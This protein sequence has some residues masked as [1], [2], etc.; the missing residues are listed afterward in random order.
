MLL[1]FSGLDGSGKSTLIELLI[2]HKKARKYSI[3][4]LTMYDHIG[5]FALFRGLRNGIFKFFG[6]PIK[7]KTKLKFGNS[8]DEIIN[9]E[10]RGWFMQIIL[11]FLRQIWIKKA[12]LLL[13]IFIMHGYR[14]YFERI[15][16]NVLILD[17]YFYDSLVD[18][19][20]KKPN[21]NF[22]NM[23]LRYIPQPTISIFI[24]VP[25]K[26]SF[27]RKGEFSIEYLENRYKFYCSIFSKKPEIVVLSNLDQVTAKEEL[28]EKV[29]NQIFLK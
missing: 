2:N 18:I 8:P 4:V 3:K 21:D 24:D 14:L 1:T 17:R 9:A 19:L 5:L 6:S 25:P 27:N 23:I 10:N 28:T 29:I 7:D 22:M 11:R 13:D 12:V 26:T 20:I 16:K 15:C